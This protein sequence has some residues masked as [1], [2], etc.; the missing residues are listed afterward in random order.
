VLNDGGWIGKSATYAA[1]TLPQTSW[2]VAIEAVAV[3][4]FLS[5]NCTTLCSGAILLA[6]V[7]TDITLHG[8]L[9]SMGIIVS[10]LIGTEVALPIILRHGTLEHS[11]DLDGDAWVPALE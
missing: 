6:A 3:I 9:Y 5:T 10:K 1:A 8:D 4:I 11:S 7:L 2:M